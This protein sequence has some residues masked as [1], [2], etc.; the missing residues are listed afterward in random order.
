[1]SGKVPPC[2]DC[3]DRK[4]GCHGKCE[5]YKKY[6]DE[7]DKLNEIIRNANQYGSTVRQEIQSVKYNGKNTY[8]TNKSSFIIHRKAMGK[9]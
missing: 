1:M 7:L 9:Q 4:I 6:R 3:K 2:K 5:L 8:Y